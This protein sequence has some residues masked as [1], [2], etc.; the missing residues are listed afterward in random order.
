MLP[1]GGDLDDD[2]RFRGDEQKNRFVSDSCCTR[3]SFCD[4]ALDRVGFERDRAVY[5]VDFSFE[6]RT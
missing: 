2:M 3:R 4:F 6:F 5:L 1:R